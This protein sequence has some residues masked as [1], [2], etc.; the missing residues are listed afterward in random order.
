MV[1]CPIQLR[2]ENQYKVYPIGKLED[3]EVEID[4]VKSKEDPEVP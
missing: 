2:L 3:V 1:W 4:G